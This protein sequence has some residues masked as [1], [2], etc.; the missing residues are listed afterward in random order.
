MGAR[1]V[2]W[3]TQSSIGLL[4]MQFTTE[5]RYFL[6]FLNGHRKQRYQV[7]RSGGGAG[8]RMRSKVKVSQPTVVLTGAVPSTSG[9]RA[10]CHPPGRLPLTFLTPT[11]FFLFLFFSW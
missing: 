4:R 2:G 1:Q 8:L 7:F 9:T 10:I 11:P 3:P 5:S 6:L